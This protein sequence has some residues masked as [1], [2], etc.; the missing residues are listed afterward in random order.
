M[1]TLSPLSLCLSFLF[2][3]L[4]LLWKLAG[5][6]LNSKRQ[7]GSRLKKSWIRAFH[8]MLELPGWAIL[9][10]NKFTRKVLRCTT[11]VFAVILS[12][13]FRIRSIY[14]NKFNLTSMHHQTEEFF[15]VC[16]CRWDWGYFSSHLPQ[17]YIQLDMFVY[18]SGRKGTTTKEKLPGVNVIQ[19]FIE[20]LVCFVQFILYTD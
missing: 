14:R 13:E 19:C 18:N 15:L 11:S 17:K 5:K 6:H 2:R 16:N 10:I 4:F 7:L 3:N 8:G 12:K 20:L 1:R 9:R